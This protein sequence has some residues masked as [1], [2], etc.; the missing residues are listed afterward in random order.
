ME[1]LSIE[2][3]ERG[4]VPDPLARAGMRRLIGSRLRTPQARD[5]AARDAH[6]R[7]FLARAASGPIAQ[8]TA[9]ANAQHYELPPAFFE[10]VLGAHL[11]YSGCLFEKGIDDLDQAEHAMLALTAERARIRDGHRILDLGC[12]WGSF[13]L[14]AARRFP[15]AEIR[16]VSNSN[17]QRE[18]IAARAAE[19][20][21]TNLTVETCDINTFD[22]GD[23][24]FDR[25]VSVEMFEHMRNYRALFGEC[26]R[27]LD[28]HGRLFVHVFA[29]KQLAYAFTNDS[30]NDWM[31]RHF[32][33]GGIMPSA[34]LFAH[35][36]EDLILRD[37]WWLSGT[38]YRDTSNAWLARMDNA[39]DRIMPVMTETYGAEHAERWFNRWRMFFMAVAELFGY[40]GG[41]EWGIGHYLFT[42]RRDL[43]APPTRPER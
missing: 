19:R 16:A 30:T 15:H 29:H 2:A 5:P 20:G 12:G 25:I 22:P 6:M 23:K 18:W 35:F 40:A 33:T 38:H 21:L 7:E 1:S 11:K 42:P 8:H 9:D 10:A 24:R 37:H 36:Q 43:G 31:A 34:H 41:N 17:G 28:D 39:R 13:S 4:L 3:C 26:A 32:F 27:W 14:W